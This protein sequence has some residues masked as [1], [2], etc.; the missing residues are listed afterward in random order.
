VSSGVLDAS[1]LLAFLF[2]EP[3]GEAVRPLLRGG[4]I[5]SVNAGE[6]L[7]RTYRNGDSLSRH[8]KAFQSLELEVVDFNMEQAAIAASFKPYATAANL[9]FADR[10]CLALGAYRELPVFTADQ[11]W[12]DIALGVDVKLIRPRKKH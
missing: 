11:K 10:A 2:S 4:L 7:Y 8:V 5:S 12:L 9:S 6:V 1:V 3:G